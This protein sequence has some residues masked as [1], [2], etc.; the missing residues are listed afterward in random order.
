M[1]RREEMIRLQVQ[2]VAD[3]ALNIERLGLPTT[4][5]YLE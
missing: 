5:G 3:I 2:R 4:P 1:P